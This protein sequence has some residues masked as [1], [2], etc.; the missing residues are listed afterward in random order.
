LR[1]AEV[2]AKIKAEA[3]VEMWFI[4]HPVSRNQKFSFEIT[5]KYSEITTLEMRK[6]C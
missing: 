2:E 6:I 1:K 5:D 4:Q 3:E